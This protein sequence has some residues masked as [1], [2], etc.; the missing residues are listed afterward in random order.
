MKY[1]A[2]SDTSGLLG[3]S[4]I[5]N[6]SLLFEKFTLPANF[7]N[8]P[9]EKDQ[10]LRA[11]CDARSAFI[12]AK[13]KANTLSLLNRAT[14]SRRSKT[15]FGKLI[16]RMAINLAEG[17]LEN[18]GIALD[19]NTG[20]PYIPASA[21]KGCCRNAAYWMEKSD[22]IGAGTADRLF[23]T[24]E[25]QGI[26]TFL[27]AFPVEPAKLTLDILTPHP[28]KNG[29]EGDPT[30]NKFPVVDT[31]AVFAFNYFIAPKV[32]D[33]C[34]DQT[35][36]ELGAIFEK[37][38]ELGIGAKTAAGH[39]WFQRETAKETQFEECQREIEETQQRKREAEAAEREK[40]IARERQKEEQ[41]RLQAEAAERKLQEEA[42]AKAE[43]ENASPLERLR[44]GWTNLSKD[45]LGKELLRIESKPLEEQR[46]LLEVFASK[47]PKNQKK[48]L[49]DKKIGA[50]IKK[51][52]TNL[53]F[54]LP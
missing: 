2:S 13:R 8:Q 17:L 47:N 1:A 37:A 26:I 16:S 45:E 6:P 48:Y 24:T 5:E 21:I 46:T 49:K 25:R 34:L 27:P 22:A 18:S 36:R 54:Q 38:F 52:A 11:I 19:R 42:K 12:E 29:V 20:A 50:A 53:N 51:A 23:G 10:A 44:I 31:G 43:Y 33:R 7:R 30:P 39:G 14:Y 9:S 28:R 41:D 35:H 32:E 15:I 3:H 40:Q 4:R